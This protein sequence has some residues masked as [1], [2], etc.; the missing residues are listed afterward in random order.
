M[1]TKE[2]NQLA[3]A[4]EAAAVERYI[5]REWTTD[6]DFAVHSDRHG[7]KRDWFSRMLGWLAAR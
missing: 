4:Q 1:P 6:P 5:P 2:T 3:P 7:T